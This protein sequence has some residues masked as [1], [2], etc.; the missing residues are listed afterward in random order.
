[1][2]A[3]LVAVMLSQ[4]QPAKI[5][6]VS[7]EKYR[8]MC[9][10]RTKQISEDAEK[11]FVA[12]LKERTNLTGA[13]V[14]KRKKEIQEKIA[15]AKALRDDFSQ[16]RDLP[17]LL[18]KLAPGSIGALVSQEDTY[19]T[20]GFDIQLTI[21]QIVDKST[22]IGELPPGSRNG[23]PVIVAYSGLETEGLF[24][25]GKIEMKNVVIEAFGTY[26]YET[27]EGLQQTVVA[28]RNWKH[29]D[30]WQELKKKAPEEKTKDK[31]STKKVKAK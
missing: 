27:T 18:V 2:V 28:I 21:L 29:N 30:E 6:D 12:Q 4:F 25:G 11:R 13:A 26:S 17:V 15:K 22:L 14:G 10:E 3:F 24:D 5:E 23:P 1:M 8:E 19:D 7:L 31:S 16:I 20:R 9:V